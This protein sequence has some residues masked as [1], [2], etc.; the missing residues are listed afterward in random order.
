[1]DLTAK[2]LELTN[3][4]SYETLGLDFGPGVNVISGDNAQG[5]T[6]IL[7]AI[8]LCSCARS[9]RTSKDTELINDDRDHY[10]VT[11][12][13]D[14]ANLKDEEIRLAYWLAEPGTP[15]RGQN[16]R[17]FWHNGVQEERI[18]DLY[19]LF[20][21]VIF[22][23]EDL[24]LIK[25]GP[26]ARRRFLDLLLS[27]IH[28]VY[29][30]NLQTFNHLLKQRNKLLKQ[31]RDKEWHIRPNAADHL[32][33]TLN[34]W[35]EQ[36]AEAASDLIKARF[37][38]AREI[39]RHA[40][41]YHLAIS[42]EQ[43]HLTIRYKTM[44]GLDVG[45]ETG[46][47]AY[48]IKVKLAQQR[49]DDVFRGSTNLGPHRDDLIFSL[50]DEPLS[51]YGSQGQQR[52]AVLSLKLAELEIVKHETKRAP[53]LLLDDVM[54]ELDRQRRTSLVSAIGTGQVFITCTDTEQIQA[55]LKELEQTVPLT[56]FHV[57]AGSAKRLN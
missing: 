19:G 33:L 45:M 49:V 28:P 48:K 10:Q 16:Q 44:S 9:H 34:I 13:Y 32:A 56:Y 52:T 22:A 20:N 11:L 27:Q 30:S 42:S 26:Q 55:E 40:E 1:M 29:F 15:G 21:A 4:R 41:T 39:H 12:T 38:I 54:S 36:Y 6:N 24:M 2:R 47:I 8:Y 31:L 3:Y 7:E 53:V 18:A 23:P 17:L 5:K 43:E 51:I 14:D 50:N 35:D 57:A 46:E 25:D 37:L